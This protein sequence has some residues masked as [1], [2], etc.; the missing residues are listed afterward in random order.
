VNTGRN[1]SGQDHLVALGT[2]DAAMTIGTS[3]AIGGIL[4]VLATGQFPDVGFGAAPLPGPEGGDGGVLVG[5]ASLYLVEKGA[6]DAEKAASWDFVRWLNEPEQ[7]ATWHEGTGYIPIRTEAVDL[8][9]VAD[10]WERQPQYRVPYDQ[11]LDRGASFGGPVIGD[12]EGFREAIIE[13]LERMILQDKAPAEALAEAE[14]A[15]TR[16]IE[17]YNRRV[18]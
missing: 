5:G 1:P 13:S 4:A 18:S 9:E 17:D 11:L 15:A 8:P 12:Y 14:A 6:S 7:Q 3:A 10:L 2:G 16:A